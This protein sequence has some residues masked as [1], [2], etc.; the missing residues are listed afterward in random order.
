MHYAVSY[1]RYYTFDSVNIDAVLGNIIWLPLDICFICGLQYM[2][3]SW[4]MYEV[5]MYSNGQ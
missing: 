2:Y 5:Q 4:Q 3:L 1:L